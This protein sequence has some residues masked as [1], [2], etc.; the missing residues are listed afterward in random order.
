ML[1]ASSGRL[2]DLF[3][4]WLDSLLWEFW[5]FP[6]WPVCWRPR[7]AT[8]TGNLAAGIVDHGPRRMENQCVEI[9]QSVVWLWVTT[10]ARRRLAQ[11]L[12]TSSVC[13]DLGRM[14]YLGPLEEYQRKNRH[15]SLLALYGEYIGPNGWRLSDGSTAIIVSVEVVT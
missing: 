8:L 14:R 7:P 11:G 4:R 15:E 6:E 2:G 9:S 13:S 3:K 10:L 12:V 1:S 5:Q